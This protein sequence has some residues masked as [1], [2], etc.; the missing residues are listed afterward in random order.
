M[1]IM[2]FDTVI[3]LTLLI[4]S[5]IFAVYNHYKSIVIYNKYNMNIDDIN[6]MLK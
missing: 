3:I 5:F 2:T 1:I 4:S 6:M